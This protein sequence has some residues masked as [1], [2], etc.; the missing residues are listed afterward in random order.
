MDKQINV[1]WLCNYSLQYLKDKFDFEIDSTFFHPA[2]WMLYLNNEIQKRKNI[3]LHLITLSSVVDKDYVFNQNNVT[4]YIVKNSVRRFAERMPF[5]NL[6]PLYHICESVII[7]KYIKRKVL[8][9]INSVKP[10]VVN[11]HGTE[12]EFGTVLNEINL[13]SIIWIQG[14]ITQVVKADHHI[15]YKGRLKNEIELFSK[16]KNF[17]TIRGSMEDIISRY[18]SSP[19]YYHLFHPNSGDTFKLKDLEVEKDSDLVYVGQIVKRKG[20]EDFIEAINNIKRVMPGI[21]AKIIGYG[22]GNY[23]KYIE[24]KIDEYKLGDNINMLGFVASYEDVLLEV[25]K[26][27]IFVLPTYVDSGP[28]SVAESMTLGVPVISYNIDGLPAMIE[29]HVSGIL[30]EKGNIDELGEAI[31]ELLRNE[32][33]RKNI[34]ENAYKFAREN[35]YAPKVI[36]KLIEIYYELS[37]L[38]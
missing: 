14:M 17:I 16:Q 11:L 35:F 19:H 1:V 25:K 20:I 2:T 15:K 4:Y 23:Q 7:D 18:N 8:K 28:R 5:I 26:S 9:I 27:K 31:L 12:G 29:N 36:D 32:Q 3:H 30:V 24:Q 10:D 37:N 22:G 34:S 13:P 33:L 21:K 6:Q 38:N